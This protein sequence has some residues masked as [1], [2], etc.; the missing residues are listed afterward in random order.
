V[1]YCDD[2]EENQIFYLMGIGPFFFFFFLIVI[3]NFE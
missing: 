2:L 3:N 1:G